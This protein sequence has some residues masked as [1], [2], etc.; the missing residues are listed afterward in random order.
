MEY[1]RKRF[2]NG[3]DNNSNKPGTIAFASVLD[4][5]TIAFAPVLGRVR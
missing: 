1:A 2:H 3:E 5:G 4:R